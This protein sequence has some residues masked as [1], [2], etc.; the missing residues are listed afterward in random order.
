MITIYSPN[1]GSRIKYVIEFI[2][3]DL[4]EIEFRLTNKVNDLKGIVINYSNKKLELVNYQ[5]FPSGFLIN[6]NRDFSQH[7]TD[8]QENQPFFP[9]NDGHH[10]FDIFSAIFFLISRMEEYDLKNL[11]EHQRFISENSYLVK[12]EIEDQPVIDIWVMELLKK[13]NNH[14]KTELICSKKFQQYC[15]FDIDNAYAF[16]YKGILR[17]LGSFL[18]DLSL[19]RIAKLGQRFNVFFNVKNDPYDNYHYLDQFLKTRKLK[20]IFFFLL[21]DYGKMDKNINHSHPNLIKLIQSLSEF[22]K[23]GIHPSYSS[24]NNEKVIKKEIFNLK[25]INSKKVE[26]SRFHYLRFSFPKSFQIL[27]SLGI[28]KDFSMG[29]TDRIGFR[30]GTCT[31]FYFYD[32]DNEKTTNL[33]IVP[34]VYMDGVLNDKLKYSP[35]KCIQIIIDI[36]QKVKDVDGQFTCVWHNESLSNQDRWIGWRQVFESTWLD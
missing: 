29:Y 35:K 15:T 13:L 1:S 25:N 9:T 14:F 2:F 17:Y 24:L 6:G 23:I 11:D 28:K 5:I 27:Q 21:G 19:L 22:H 16:K 34:F 12:F 3:R 18:K 33:K 4:L 31:P 32:L 26:L 36:K 30:A 8:S 7:L 10:S 20:A